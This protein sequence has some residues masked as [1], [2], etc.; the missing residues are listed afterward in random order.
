MI[1]GEVIDL[2]ASCRGVSSPPPGVF[3]LLRVAFASNSRTRGTKRGR[4]GEARQG[5]HTEASAGKRPLESA[6]PAFLDDLA[7][8]LESLQGAVA[9]EALEALLCENPDWVRPSEWLHN[10]GLAQHAL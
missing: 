9:T 4:P 6:L 3:K 8:S 10:F 1:L 7:S 2:M 5:T